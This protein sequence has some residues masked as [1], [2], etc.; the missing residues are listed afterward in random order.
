MPAKR[1]K[2]EEARPTGAVRLTRLGTKT[3]YYE[4]GGLRWGSKG[5]TTEPENF[6]AALTKGQARQVRKAARAA[7]LNT[8]AAAPRMHVVTID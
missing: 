5:E 2:P 7:G 8:V 3:V 1:R 6:Y 4:N